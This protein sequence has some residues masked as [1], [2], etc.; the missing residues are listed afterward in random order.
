MTAIKKG[1]GTIQ[2]Q[3]LALM[4]GDSPTTLWTRDDFMN[5]LGI[6]MRPA[7]NAC[8]NAWKSGKIYRHKDKDENKLF[9]YALSIK[10]QHREMYQ[11]T[12]GA[13]PGP[14]RKKKSKMITA[15]EL[16]K[17]FAAHMNS[18]A[19]LEDIV[20]ELVDRLEELEK[21]HEKIKQLI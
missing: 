9:S 21:S 14:A 10:E 1:N 12:T 8:Y 18:S 6:E 16:R 7:E 20:L 17:L 3:M 4:K 13:T 2:Q 19:Q 15:K 11:P 5:E